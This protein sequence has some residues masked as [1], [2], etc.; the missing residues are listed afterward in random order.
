MF[1]VQV[2]RRSGKARTCTCYKYN[3]YMLCM[4][5]YDVERGVHRSCARLTVPVTVSDGREGGG[6]VCVV[7]VGVGVP[8]FGLGCLGLL[9]GVWMLVGWL[10]G[11]RGREA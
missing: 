6:P 9:S 2:R 7:C 10:V 4:C 5:M 1:E 8:G 11:M 3:M